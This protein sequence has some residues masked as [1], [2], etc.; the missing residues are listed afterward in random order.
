MNVPITIDNFGN[1]IIRVNARACV[2]LPGLDNRGHEP[3]K[4]KYFETKTKC[5]ISIL[6]TLQNKILG[7]QHLTI[8]TIEE[9][10]QNTSKHMHTN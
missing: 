6:A 7:F 2:D 4:K 8:L 10:H 1:L 3:L 9:M 5:F